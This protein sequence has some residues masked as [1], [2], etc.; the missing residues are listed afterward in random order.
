MECGGIVG[1]VCAKTQNKEM[2]KKNRGYEEEGYVFP[3]V[4]RR[5][6]KSGQ[7]ER[8]IIDHRGLRRPGAGE[9]VK[10]RKVLCRACQFIVLNEVLGNVGA[11]YPFMSA[12]TR[13]RGRR[14]HASYHIQNRESL[15]SLST[16]RPGVSIRGTLRPAGGQGVTG[17]A[18]APSGNT[19]DMSNRRSRHACALHH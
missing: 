18:L 4:V 10:P 5:G 1:W 12:M 9:A 6:S 19:R 7:R 14:H 16:V 2:F 17:P 8:L 13:E 3:R 15:Q 11:T